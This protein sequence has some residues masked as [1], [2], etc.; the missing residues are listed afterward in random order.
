[1]QKLIAF[2]LLVAIITNITTYYFVIE[3]LTV[4]K[5]KEIHYL[6]AKDSECVLKGLHFVDSEENP[7]DFKK[8]MMC[9]EVE[10]D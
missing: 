8:P 2:L 10:G 1:M 4:V 5:N 7:F 9:R 3:Q 6:I